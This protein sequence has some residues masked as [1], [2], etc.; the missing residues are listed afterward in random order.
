MAPCHLGFLPL[1][2]WFAGI[3]AGCWFCAA[4]LRTVP[5]F[6][7]IFSTIRVCDQR[8]SSMNTTRVRACVL[9]FSLSVFLLALFVVV[10]GCG[11]GYGAGSGGGGGTAPYI[12]TQPTNQT[13]AVGQA[14]T[15]SVVANGTAPLS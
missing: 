9:N 1:L 5:E 6:G 7:R 4:A 10:N 15:F 8:K 12:T 11:G 3:F 13:V 2:V 14:A